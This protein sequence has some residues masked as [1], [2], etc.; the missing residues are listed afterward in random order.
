MKPMAPDRKK[1]FTIGCIVS[2]LVIFALF[3][4]G[5]SGFFFDGK[6]ETLR[7]AAVGIDVLAILVLVA[8][9]ITAFLHVRKRGDLTAQEKRGWYAGLWLLN[10]VLLP[11][12]WWKLVRPLPEDRPGGG[13]GQR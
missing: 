2:P 10:V 11:V 12:F 13:G 8:T 7:H 5:M 9:A 1:L 6:H 4:L 3:I